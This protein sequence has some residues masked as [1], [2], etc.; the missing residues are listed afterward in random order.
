MFIKFQSLNITLF[1]WERHFCV[2]SYHGVPDDNSLYRILALRWA[3]T[4]DSERCKGQS[5][6]KY[7]PAEL[8]EQLMG[9]TPCVGSCFCHHMTLGT[10]GMCSCYRAV[11]FSLSFPLVQML[12]ALS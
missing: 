9:V 3:I 10:F 7:V 4:L 1:F 5:Y 2:T 8:L 6:A 11:L 12:H